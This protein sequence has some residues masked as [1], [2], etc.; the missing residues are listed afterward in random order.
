L[1]VLEEAIANAIY[2]RDYQVREPVEVRIYPDSICILNYGGPDRSIKSNA[3][4][5]GPVKPR[6]YRNRRL[7]DFLKELDLTEGKATGIP[8]IKKSLK[9][10][11]SPEPFFDF[12][13]DRTFF[14]VDFYIHPAF[15][16]KTEIPATSKFTNI[17]KPAE[18]LKESAMRVLSLIET[19]PQITAAEIA[20]K[21][22]I[23]SR[24]AQKH[25]A[26][27]KALSMISRKGSDKSGYWEITKA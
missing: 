21:L 12:D 22:G 8:R 16:E 23:S 24:A 17:N 7:G 26:N 18:T 13:E 2:H 9:E 20:I 25:I 19:N 5:I 10:N 11:G 15:K 3:F 14:E 27:L 6:R 4:K 1:E